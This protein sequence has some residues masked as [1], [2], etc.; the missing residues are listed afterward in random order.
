MINLLERTWWG[1]LW[2]AQESLLAENV[3]VA[4]GASNV[5]Q[6]TLYA[7]LKMIHD[8]SLAEIYTGSVDPS[9][10]KAMLIRSLSFLMITLALELQFSGD[11]GLSLRQALEDTRDRFYCTDARDKV[12]ALVGFLAKSEQ[13]KIPIDYAKSCTEVFSLAPIALLQD[14]G[15]NILSLCDDKYLSPTTFLPS[16][17]P[18]LT[19]RF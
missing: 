16:W 14:H 7:G 12:F 8:Y 15:P 2:V 18:D 5:S 17:I 13:S 6:L 1:R 10:T 4:Y 19:R 3:I 11:G 9:T